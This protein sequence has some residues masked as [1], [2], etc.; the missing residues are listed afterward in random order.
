LELLQSSNM[1]VYLMNTGSIAGDEDDERSK[2]VKIR[3][4]SAIVKAIAEEAIEWEEDPYFGYAVA[5]LVPGI[6]DEDRDL[7]Q[8]HLRYEEQ[9]RREE[10]DRQVERYKRERTEHL[11]SY[12][13]LDKRIIDAV[14]R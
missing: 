10:H 8:P 13:G 2:K 4:S 5:A 12:P 14:E 3:H 6:S 11:K 9:G 1:D 7:R